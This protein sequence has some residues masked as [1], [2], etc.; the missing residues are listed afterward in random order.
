[1]SIKG[2]IRNFWD[3]FQPMFLNAYFLFFFCIFL[4]VYHKW[5]TIRY[6]LGDLFK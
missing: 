3:W 2:K 4:F 6:F 1:M 5:D